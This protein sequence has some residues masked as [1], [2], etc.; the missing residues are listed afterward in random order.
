MSET[1]PLKPTGQPNSTLSA[2][3]MKASKQAKVGNFSILADKS[4]EFLRAWKE[5]AGRC[6]DAGHAGLKAVNENMRFCVLG[7][8]GFGGAGAALG[9]S[10][11][12]VGVAIGA[13][14]GGGIGFSVIA[15][16]HFVPTAIEA[17]T[18]SKNRAQNVINRPP[19]WMVEGMTFDQV[20]SA[21]LTWNSLMTS[22][23]G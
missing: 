23:W 15:A 12:P 9:S 4:R 19:G 1:T 3:D 21:T 10:A 18:V 16:F 8:I 5:T 6:L 13:A 14:V 11:G 20:Q 2:S 7:A 22:T 17:Y